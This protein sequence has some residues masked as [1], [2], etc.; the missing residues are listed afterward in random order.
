MIA[1]SWISSSA[2]SNYFPRQRPFATT[3]ASTRTVEN[4]DRTAGR[5]AVLSR[6]EPSPT[7]NFRGNAISVAD[8]FLQ[9]QQK[10]RF[11]PCGRLRLQLYSRHGC[12]P[13]P[14]PGAI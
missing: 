8:N 6:A 10:Q 4:S 13:A 12:T 2:R 9:K 7:Y 1:D 5:R 14:L 11:A 3:L